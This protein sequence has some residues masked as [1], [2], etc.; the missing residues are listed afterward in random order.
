MAAAA[1]DPGVG[2]LH[3]QSAGTATQLTLTSYSSA[4]AADPSSNNFPGGTPA[5]IRSQVAGWQ[6]GGDGSF[7]IAGVDVPYF[8]AH[9][10]FALYSTTLAAGSTATAECTSC[11]AGKTRMQRVNARVTGA[12]TANIEIEDYDGTGVAQADQSVATEG[13]WCSGVCVSGGTNNRQ[14][15]IKSNGSTTATI[16]AYCSGS[17]RVA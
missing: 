16:T 7:R 9:A 6:L 11:P 8:A 3:L 2:G 1:G 4:G 13:S 15:K 14:V 5:V 10:P 12:T 17:W